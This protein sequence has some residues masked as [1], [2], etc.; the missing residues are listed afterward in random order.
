MRN[1]GCAIEYVAKTVQDDTP[2]GELIE[3]FFDSLAE[4]CSA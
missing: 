4:S 3:S 2:E 1:A